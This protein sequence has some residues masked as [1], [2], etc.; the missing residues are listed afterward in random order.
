MRQE[1][2]Q[3]SRNGDL[4]RSGVAVA[5]ERWG[6]GAQLAGPPP[7]PPQTQVT[8]RH[9]SSGL[10]WLGARLTTTTVAHHSQPQALALEQKQGGGRRCFFRVT[11]VARWHGVASALP[12]RSCG[13]MSLRESPVSPYGCPRSPT[14]PL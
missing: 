8:H 14:L 13:Q 11:G 4:R 3:R 9:C 10:G 5:P 7:P 1:Q 2:R 6:E 12:A